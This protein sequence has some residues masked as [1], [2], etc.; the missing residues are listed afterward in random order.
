MLE[1]VELFGEFIT[2]L[3]FFSKALQLFLSFFIF[4]LS[5]VSDSK[6]VFKDILRLLLFVLQN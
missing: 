1:M 3:S 2:L 6:Y 4:H 5:D